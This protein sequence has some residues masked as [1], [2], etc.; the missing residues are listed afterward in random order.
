MVYRRGRLLVAPAVCAFLL[1]LGIAS[2]QETGPK[3]NP[4]F[5]AGVDLVRNEDY[6]GA[7]DKLQAATNA[8]PTLEPAWYYLGVAQFHLGNLQE[9]VAAFQKA[10]DLRPGRPEIRIYVGQIY[11]QLGAYREAIDAYGEEL[12]LRAGKDPSDVYNALTRAHFMAG[13][14]RAAAEAGYQA[15]LRDT[16]YVEALFNWAR[17]EDALERYDQAIKLL[18]QARDILVQWD[19][20]ETRLQRLI[21]EKRSDPKVTEEKVAQEY[22]RAREFAMQLRLWPTLNKVLGNVYLHANKFAEARNAFRAAMD[23]TQKGNSQDP[24]AATLI[25]VAYYKDG[26]DLLL[27]QDVLFQAIQ[28]LKAAVKQLN[29]ALTMDPNWAPAYNALGEVYVLESQT[30]VSDPARGI[31]SHTPEDAEQQLRRAL[32]LDP[33]YVDAM[34]NLAR[35]YNGQQR[36]DEALQQLTAALNL[37]PNR[38][39][40]H[41][42]LA[43]TYVGLER[44]DEAREEAMIAVQ[45]DAKQIAAWNA[46]G[47]AAYYRNSLGDAVEYFTKAVEIDTTQHQSHTNLGLAFFQMRTWTRARQEFALALKYLPQAAITN[48]AYQRSYLYY[49]T[50]LTYSNTGDHPKAIEAL[51]EA[52]ALDSTYFDALRQLARDYVALSD[53]RAAD[54]AL[55]RALQQSPGTTEDAEVY[56]QLGRV[57]EAAGQ[58]HMALAAYS[59]AITKDSDNLEAQN[60]FA[61]L[62]AY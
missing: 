23:A 21:Q 37:N 28:V 20:L 16:N 51:N 46:A 31:I 45:I 54:A 17:A 6:A 40:L 50:G 61:R 56:A 41:A 59:E 49:L 15:T 26:L 39:D 62:Q 5:I 57:Y 4:D 33:Q 18:T 52:L 43:Q 55:R 9:A 2:A 8:E 13:N 14:Y 47:L 1:L 3:A 25:G 12:R 48:T 27:K 36:Y 22:G 32:E 53:Y 29:E 24:D 44:Y 60:G 11:E 42:Q 7:L 35:A 19:S 30:F 58:P 38:A 10:L 34:L